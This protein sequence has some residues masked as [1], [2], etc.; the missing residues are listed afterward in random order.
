MNPQQILKATAGAGHQ[1]HNPE[2]TVTKTDF[3]GSSQDRHGAAWAGD[4]RQLLPHLD[5]LPLLPCGW[6][7]EKKAPMLDQWEAASF[8][9]HEIAAMNG[10]VR[11]VGTRTGTDAGGLVSFDIDGAT[12]LELAL[13][14]GCDPQ[15]AHT[16]QVHRNTDPCR[17]KVNWQLTPK[18]QLQIGRF[19]DKARTKLPPRDANGQVLLDSNGKRIKGE[20]VEVFHHPGRQIVVIGEHVASGGHYCW[21]EGCGPE[22]LALIPPN[23]WQLL[24]RIQAKELGIQE[25]TVASRASTSGSSSK[26][27]WESLAVC[28]ICSRDTTAYCSRHRG[29]GTVRCFHGS[30]FNPTYRHQLD[31]LGAMVQGSDGIAYGYAGTGPQSNGDVF[32]TFV[33]HQDRPPDQ[34]LQ[35]QPITSDQLGQTSS[36]GKGNGPAPA[37]EDERQERRKCLEHLYDDLVDAR[38]TGEA[39]LADVIVADIVCRNITR[40]R[41][42]DEVIQRWARRRGYQLPN[43]VGIAPKRGRMI[44]HHDDDTAPGITALLP[45]FINDHELHVFAA[46]AGAGKTHQTLAMIRAI[47][48]RRYG[49][50]DQETPRHIN[51]T[52]TRSTVLY[53][54]TDGEGGS[55][56]MIADYCERVGIGAAHNLE[57]WA[58]DDDTGE[59]AWT[60]SLPN[61]ERL[62]Q[63]LADGD[64]ALV[65]IDTAKAAIEGA[66][67]S[68]GIGPVG[69][70]LRTLKA[71]VCRHCALWI[72]H[73]TNR[74]GRGIKSI[75]SHPAFME[76]PGGVHTLE[77]IDRNGEGNAWRW[78][79]Q[80]LRG[81]ER[82]SFLFDIGPDGPRVIEGH[83]YENCREQVLAVIAARWRGQRDTPSL[84]TTPAALAEHTGRPIKSIYNALDQLRQ[85][86]LIRARG[87]GYRP[88]PQGERTAKPDTHTPPP[89]PSE[90][91]TS[92]TNTDRDTAAQPISR[93]IPRELPGTKTPE[94]L[95]ERE[96]ERFFPVNG[97]LLGGGGGSAAPPPAYLPD[98]DD[99]AWGPRPEVQS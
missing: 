65:V 91:K 61:L 82:R 40:D 2:R 78:T 84:P 43:A 16:W 19:T 6:G 58:Q 27:E 68:I 96:R 97:F 46:D 79:V 17:L 11:C 72:N 4:W 89:P 59:A 77:L 57:V 63:R 37:P 24:L 86:R 53:I 52:D 74:T 87:R 38:L 71:I 47:Q 75:A 69:T 73:H 9:P 13:Q 81:S 80:K 5:G 8:A 7:D 88:T 32:S 23:W 49:F 62:A 92:G 18:Q 10:A 41:I 14:E 98:D 76:V 48:E 70:Y 35:L 99:P 25:T 12:A 26:G 28:P 36:N 60:V 29:R 45:G 85:Q 95:Q 22:A 50:L 67:I 93:I 55:F 34:P 21:P 39:T 3:T 56:G 20:A 42:E 44:G 83:F 30:T 64:V 66:G 33:V 90:N 31:H 94:P 51:T 54:A 1:S 15:Q